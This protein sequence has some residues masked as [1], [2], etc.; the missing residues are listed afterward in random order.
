M[1]C[2]G[3][4]RRHKKRFEILNGSAGDEKRPLPATNMT[5]L[6]GIAYLKQHRKEGRGHTRGIF[7]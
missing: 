6:Q 3:Q 5:I 2:W 1:E 4:R 7:S